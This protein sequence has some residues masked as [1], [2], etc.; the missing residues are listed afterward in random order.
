MNIK[1]KIISIALI[2]FGL[3]MAAIGVRAATVLFVPQG[4]TG[5]GTFTDGGVII[6]NGTGALQV[7]SAGTSGYVLT[8]TGAGSDPTFQINAALGNPGAWQTV[9]TN[10][11]APTSTTAGIFVYAS[12]TFNSTLRVNGAA[13]T[14]SLVIG[15][16]NPNATFGQSGDLFAGR[17]TTTN[18]TVTSLNAS[19]C[20]LKADT[21]GNFYCGTDSTGS[22]GISIIWN[23]LANSIIA[24]TNTSAHLSI[25][26]STRFNSDFF[27]DGT[28]GNASSTGYLIL[29]SQ[30]TIN[31]ASGDL[32]AVRATSTALA[33]TG[34]TAS[35]LVVT[36]A[37][38][39]FI[40]AGTFTNG[41]L[42]IGDGDGIPTKGTITAGT[43]ITV[44]NGAGSITIGV[45]AG[46][47]FSPWNTYTG[48]LLAPTNTS[49]ALSIG[50]Q[51]SQ[52]PFHVTNAGAASSTSQSI[53]GLFKVNSSGN[54]TS[55]RLDVTNGSHGVRV[56]PGNTT[57]TLEFY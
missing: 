10:T 41:Q 17:A 21:S 20:D 53:N 25:G 57:T 33:V 45:T 56:I 38:S 13:T 22:A 48:P 7:T 28:S 52:A 6:G 14:T 2:V 12:S 34:V 36:N 1:Q 16:T 39:T 54:A 9:W 31:M 49:A 37:N 5:A 11:L 15:T 35:N 8:S 51:T 55:T 40:G 30:P 18:L 43:G 4:G 27:I 46:S 42:Y 26:G 32:L 47:V 29:G 50:A 44:T 24:P 23:T 19:N 3:T